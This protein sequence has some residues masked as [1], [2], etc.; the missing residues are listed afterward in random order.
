MLCTSLTS[1]GPEHL[2]CPNV[3]SGSDTP[4]PGCAAA[5]VFHQP[6]HQR[7]ADRP[8]AKGRKGHDV[9]VE[10]AGP[11]D[12]PIPAGVGNKHI[13][14]SPAVGNVFIGGI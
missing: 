4:G 8:Q 6:W 5:V 11:V 9:A 7:P 13:P 3:S 10:L 1:P 2:V 14:A 12:Q